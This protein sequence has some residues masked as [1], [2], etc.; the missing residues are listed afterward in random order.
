V[1]KKRSFLFCFFDSAQFSQATTTTPLPRLA[2]RE[3]TNVSPTMN[4]LA[5]HSVAHP[6]A[7]RV[8]RWPAEQRDSYVLSHSRSCSSSTRTLRRK[9]TV[10]GCAQCASGFKL[11]TKPLKG[12]RAA[13][14]N[15]FIVPYCVGSVLLD[16]AENEMLSTFGQLQPAIN[17]VPDAKLNALRNLAK[18]LNSTLSNALRSLENGPN[19]ALAGARARIQ[20]LLSDPLQTV[21][22]QLSGISSLVMDFTAEEEA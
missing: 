12:R 2:H 22:G 15:S 11:A 16:A 14:A 5:L 9:M 20:D 8:Y 21:Q 19:F 13:L 18:E 10:L 6:A 4:P 1:V 17:T 7:N 3:N